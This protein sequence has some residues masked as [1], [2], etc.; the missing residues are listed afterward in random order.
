MNYPDFALLK[1]AVTFEDGDLFG[2][3]RDCPAFE[4]NE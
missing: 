3:G 4:Q 2:V 1:L